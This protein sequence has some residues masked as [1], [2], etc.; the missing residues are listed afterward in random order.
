VRPQHWLCRCSTISFAHV[1]LRRKQEAERRAQ[2]AD[3][4]RRNR[5]REEERQRMQV[6]SYTSW[7]HHT[8]LPVLTPLQ[9]ELS[10]PPADDLFE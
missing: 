1:L 4:E 5:E 2:A 6:R 7:T 3:A 8:H 9:A 10:E